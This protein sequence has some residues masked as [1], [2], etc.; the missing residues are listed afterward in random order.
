MIVAAFLA[1]ILLAHHHPKVIPPFTFSQDGEEVQMRFVV[2]AR[3]VTLK[4][5]DDAVLTCKTLA[6]TFDNVPNTDNTLSVTL[7]CET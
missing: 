4:E 1:G 6:T 7:Y 5:W 2:D 3:Y